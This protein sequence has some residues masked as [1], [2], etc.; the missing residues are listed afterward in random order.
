VSR[1]TMSRLLDEG[2]GKGVIE[3]NIDSPFQRSAELQTAVCERFSLKEALMQD[4]HVAVVLELAR[5][6]DEAIVGI[7]S[8]VTGFSSL[9]RAGFLQEDNLL[10]LREAGAVGDICE[11]HFDLY[12]RE[13]PIDLNQ[14]MVSVALSAINDIP[15]VIGIASGKEKA[16]G[17][18]G[19]LNGVLWRC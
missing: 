8:V 17:L 13:L 7:G 18:L 2:R 1:S 14:P 3:N 9:V 5:N 19:A 11:R 4:W 10:A 15:Q 6:T 16:R 12:E